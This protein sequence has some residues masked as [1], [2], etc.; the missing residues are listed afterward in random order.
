M[1]NKL[2]QNI[3]DCFHSKQS[4]ET[5]TSNINF[6][7][8]SKEIIEN[9]SPKSKHKKKSEAVP[10]VKLPNN[11]KKLTLNDFLVE[12]EIGK[13]AFGKV[14]LVRKE[15][16]NSLVPQ[17]Y[18]MKI[19]RKKDVFENKLV[20]NIILEKTILSKQR[21]PFIVDLKYAFQTAYKVYLI[22]E[23]VPGGELFRL[24]KR[25][26]RF[27]EETARFYMCEVLLAL[28]FLH[29]K[30]NVIYR[31]LKPE[32]ILL[33]EQGHIKITDFGLAK[34]NDGKA[35]TMVGTIEY[36]APEVIKKSGYT[37]TVDYW[38]LGIL[39]YEMLAGYPPF[40]APH[41]NFQEIENLILENNPF[42]PNY[43][44]SEAIDLIKKLTNSNPE[45]RLG[46][47]SVNDIRDHTF[48][49]GI[50]WNNVLNLKVVPPFTIKNNILCQLDGQELNKEY[51]RVCET[52]NSSSKQMP[53]LNGITYNHD[54]LDSSNTNFNSK[55]LNGINENSLNMQ[56]DFRK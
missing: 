30:M 24:L 4:S 6:Q 19:I 23:Y 12:K 44:S 52:F 14:L 20:E 13:G 56:S 32:N 21:H 31:D 17:H 18:A 26:K 34:K 53:N 15:N 16:R 48:F 8:E 2:Q 38:G 7:I 54:L 42:F 36:L 40:T 27:N 29:K 46:A 37:C 3:C 35:Y 47:K 10:V 45:K 33:T 39:L 9:S 51:N 1:G 28:E 25:V 55:K 41:R 5:F 49:K 11:E 22:M 43:F 50:N